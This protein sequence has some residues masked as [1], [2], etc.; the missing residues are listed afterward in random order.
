MDWNEQAQQ[1]SNTW[2][3]AQKEMWENW[4]NLGQ[5]E[6][7]KMP[8]YNDVTKQ[9]QANIN[10]GFEA[11]TKHS[12]ATA[13]QVSHNLFESQ[14]A[15]NQFFQFYVNSWQNI[16][17]KMENGEAWQETL[18]T[19]TDQLRQQVLNWPQMNFATADQTGKLWE[20]YLQEI[21]KFS[22]PWLSAWQQAPDKFSQNGNGQVEMAQ[23]YWQAYEQTL[24]RLFESP[25]L[26]YAREMQEKANKGFKAWQAY[27]QADLAYNLA[28]GEI[29]VKLFEKFQEELVSRAEKD[30]PITDLAD[31]SKLW[32]NLADTLFVEFFYSEKYIALQNDLLKTT[33]QNR[34]EQR[35]LMENMLKAYD[36]PT[37]TEMDEAHRKNYQQKREIRA[38]KKE[39]AQ[40]KATQSTNVADDLA[41][42]RAEIETLKKSVT[43]AKPKRSTNRKT[44]KSTTSTT[45]AKTTGTAKDTA[46]ES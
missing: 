5:T 29:W 14:K 46:K 40:L 6:S 42:L 25:G 37:R 9:W 41:E 43:A 8:D 23:L 12:E 2:F 33:M 13:K 44:S 39:V 10:Q 19:Y 3:E 20:N 15:F 38:L 16:A 34:I 30:E 45:K 27:R 17:K 35:A 18:E 11:W 4:L 32:F 36:I 31:L 24:G 22:Q 7:A 1:M 28:L 21:Q 26:G